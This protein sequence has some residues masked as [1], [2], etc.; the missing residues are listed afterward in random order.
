MALLIGVILMWGMFIGYQ[1]SV[2]RFGSEPFYNLMPG[3]WMPY[4][5]VVVALSMM[6]SLAPLRD[7]LRVL[8][9]ETPVHWL[10]GIHILR[11]LAL[12]TL[13][14]AS[15][16]LFP[17][18]FAWLVGGPDLL[19]GTSAIIVT[20]LARSGR[21]SDRFILYWH[22]AGALAIVLPVA[23]LMHFFMAEPLF[24]ELFMFPMVMAPALI[25]PTL[26]LLNLLVAWRFY[27]QGALNQ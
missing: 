13:L 18:M 1:S 9:D 16:D 26:V 5:P 21:L 25:V 7:G 10:S 24:A 27:E 2:G 15:N 17:Q 4:V 3:Y 19:F 8:V 23:G 11:I 22:L 20:L 14:K 12:G 6:L